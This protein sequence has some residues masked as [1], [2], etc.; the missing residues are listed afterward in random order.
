[1][2][3]GASAT[4]A[5]P[6]LKFLACLLVLLLCTMLSWL[7]GSSDYHSTV[8]GWLPLLI[9]ICAIITARL[10]LTVLRRGLRLLEKT[11]L[12]VS[13]RGEEVTFTVRFHNIT[14][15]FF[16]R[17]KTHFFVS[18]LFGN[19]ENELISTLALSPFE[20][21]DM[22]FAVKFNHI[23]TYSAGLDRVVITDFLHLFE[24]SI[25]NPAVHTVDITPRIQPIGRIEFSNE[26]VLETSRANKSALA[27]SL[28]YACVRNYVPGDPLKTIHWKL[29]ARSENYLTRLFEVYTNPGVSVVLDTFGPSSHTNVL[30]DMFDCVIETA[31][32]VARFAQEQGLDTEVHYLSRSGVR[33]RKVA[34][35]RHEMADI[36]D[37]IPR[38]SNEATRQLDALDIVN[39]QMRSQY[40][41]NNLVVVTANLSA[42]M[43]STLIEAKACQRDPLLFAVVPSYL[44]GRE[45]EDYVAGLGRLDN[46]GIAYLILSRSEELVGVKI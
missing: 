17:I 18:D 37:E 9:A 39:E 8:V 33:V 27:D 29:S 36:V 42:Q 6:L 34:F 43:I 24:T 31:F 10:Y 38:I 35:G 1:V 5:G 21:Y 23:G 25:Q 13:Q 26:A 15:L 22:D 16:F 12:G 45:R 46:A 3:Q 30:M 2:A 28:D 44:I 19:Q 11:D 40:G 7:V 41:Q 20:A 4:G 14:P 32:S